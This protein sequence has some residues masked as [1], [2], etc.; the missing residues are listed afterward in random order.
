MD[1]SAAHL[2]IDLAA[3][4]V[5][6]AG[7]EA[8]IRDLIPELR[9]WLT[10]GRAT[11]LAGAPTAPDAQSEA[12]NAPQ[13]E[14]VAPAKAPMTQAAAVEPPTV[15]ASTAPPKR[16]A[17][18]RQRQSINIK[19][20]PV[21]YKGGGDIPS[22]Q[23]FFAQKQPNAENN[24]E[25]ATVVVYYLNNYADVP[26]VLPGH[27]VSAYNELRYRKST[28]PDAILRNIK[29][30]KGWVDGDKDGFAIT[31]SGENFVEH[32]LPPTQD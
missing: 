23:D 4:Q 19:P 17:T 16:R 29:G 14:P 32:D 30:R 5:D 26:M 12:N 18:V 21:N 28:A 1:S 7:S 9:E 22:L 2:R 6:V 20:I 11:P 10:A 31:V 27:I 24:Q 15:A 3:G 8:F 25:V 13:A